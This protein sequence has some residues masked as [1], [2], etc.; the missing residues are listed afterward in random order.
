M[1]FCFPSVCKDLIEP[2]LFFFLFGNLLLCQF[3]SAKFSNSFGLCHRIRSPD[4]SGIKISCL[5]CR[6]AF[7]AVRLYQFWHQARKPEVCLYWLWSFWL[8]YIL[9]YVPQS[10]AC[11]PLFILPC[12]KACG[13]RQ[14]FLWPLCD[15]CIDDIWPSAFSRWWWWWRRC[16]WIVHSK[17]FVCFY[18]SRVSFAGSLNKPTCN[19]KSLTKY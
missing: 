16:E 8:F 4:P 17:R 7:L 18:T 11:Q 2:C 15:E 13:A 9:V 6:L 3:H 5:I 1:E 12:L 19:V 10:M 14:S